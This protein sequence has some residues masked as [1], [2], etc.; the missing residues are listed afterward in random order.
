MVMFVGEGG[1]DAGAQFV[2]LGV[3]Q[4]EGCDLLEMVMQKPGVVNQGLQDQRLAA[5]QRAALAAHDRAERELG[6]GRLVRS[7]GKGRT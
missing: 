7:A 2:G 4:F 1:D 3:G 5:G 6:T